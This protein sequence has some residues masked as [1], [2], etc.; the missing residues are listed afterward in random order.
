MNKYKYKIKEIKVGDIKYDKGTKTTV[1]NIDPETSSITWDIQDT[2]DFGNIFK[3]LKRAEDFMFKLSKNKN[4][5]QDNTIQQIQQDL[6]IIFNKFRTHIRKNY[7]EEYKR[8]KNIVEMNTISSSS[9]FISGGEGENH[10]GPSPRKSTYGA[11]TQVGY[12]KVKENF[13]YR[14]KNSIKEDT[15]IE[16]FINGI[17]INDPDRKEFIKKRLEGFDILEN[18]LNELIPLLQSAKHKTMDYYRANPDSW[19]VLYGTDL[20]NDYLNDL[21]NLFKEQ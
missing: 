6:T 8:I 14:L 9:G 15:N 7:P 16:D 20:A 5:R 10:T 21:I 2:P 19:S 1:T 18:K 3:N 13:K 12:K 11:Y 17:S 4:I